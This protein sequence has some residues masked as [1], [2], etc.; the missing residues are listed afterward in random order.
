MFTFPWQ[1][2]ISITHLLIMIQN[3]L[4]LQWIQYLRSKQ[5]SSTTIFQER[6]AHIVDFSESH[7]N[8]KLWQ[9]LIV[10]QTLKLWLEKNRDTAAADETADTEELMDILKE[11]IDALE[12]EI[13]E[14]R[15]GISFEYFPKIQI[16]NNFRHSHTA[17][18][19]RLEMRSLK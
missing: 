4:P 9:R 14:V 6:F 12:Q 2:R 16:H 3:P 1:L 19:R 11:T 5:P 10:S 18:R 7:K 8:L 15:T 17:P 13:K